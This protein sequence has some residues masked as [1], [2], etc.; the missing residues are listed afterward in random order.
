[1]QNIIEGS[2]IETLYRMVI[3]DIKPHVFDDIMESKKAEINNWVITQLAKE[4][5]TDKTEFFEKFK[6][7]IT[8]AEYICEEKKI[9]AAAHYLAT[10]YEFKLIYNVNH[11]T[12]GIE[13]TKE[14]LEKRVEKFLDIEAV[15]EIKLKKNLNDFIKICGQLRFQIRWA[16]TPRLPKTSVLGHMYFVA[17]M[18]YFFSKMNNSC[19]KRLS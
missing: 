2:I 18:S 14:K 8:E 12:Y 7:Y 4:M 9:L 1:M 17:V 6:R 11:Y 3:T 15:K 16:Q 5:E 13:E 10:E 19:D